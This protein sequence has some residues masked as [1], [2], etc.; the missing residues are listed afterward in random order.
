MFG[1]ARLVVAVLAIGLVGGVVWGGFGPWAWGALGGLGLLFLVLVVLHARVN[2]AVERTKAGV[3]FHTR[4]LARLGL[5]WASL[6]TDSEDFR[7]P[8]HPFAGDLDVF[9]RA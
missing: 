8:D 1:A 5:D 6:S 4:G 2:D 7:K 9:G 3:R